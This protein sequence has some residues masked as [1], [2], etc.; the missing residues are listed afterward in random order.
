MW[1]LEK[2]FCLNYEFW[3]THQPKCTRDYYYYRFLLQWYNQQSLSRLVAE[4]LV[5]FCYKAA[6]VDRN[7]IEGNRRV[8]RAHSKIPLSYWLWTWRSKFE[9]SYGKDNRSL[10]RLT[11]IPINWHKSPKM[12]NST[13]TD[14]I[15]GVAW[16]NRMV[17]GQEQC[18]STDP[19]DKQINEE[20]LQ[21]TSLWNI[22]VNCKKS[23]CRTSYTKIKK[24]TCFI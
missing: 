18:H 11:W 19:A 2:C 24:K 23:D 15:F 22:A 7:E 16:F 1:L 13:S 3:C 20:M 12:T 17:A 4:E 9:M 5:V 21:P 8:A 10:W 6:L 14:V